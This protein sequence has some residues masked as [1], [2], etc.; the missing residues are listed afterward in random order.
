MNAS[1]SSFP[2][3]AASPRASSS[4]SGRAEPRVLPW[5]D[6]SF[7]GPSSARW[8]ARRS[9]V[10]LGIAVLLVAGAASLLLQPFGGQSAAVA[11]EASGPGPS[12]PIRILRDAQTLSLDVVYQHRLF[13][14]PE[15]P[16]QGPPADG[17][18][19]TGFLRFREAGKAWRAEQSV[20]ADRVKHFAWIDQSFDGAA[21]GSGEYRYHDRLRGNAAVLP[22]DAL[23]STLWSQQPLYWLASWA[24]SSSGSGGGDRL[25][26]SAFLA[27]SDEAISLADEGWSLVEVA[28]ADG[29]TLVEQLTV[30]S[31]GGGST[32]VLTAPKGEHDELLSIEEYAA[33]GTP[34][35]RVL[36][37][38]WKVPAWGPYSA[39]APR[40]LPH[41]VTVIGYDKLGM[42][43]YEAT[44]SI[45]ACA[46]DLP[47]SADDLTASLEGATTIV[48]E[49]PG[50]SPQ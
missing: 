43:L 7:G 31:G 36:F 2:R 47:M 42:S 1:P 12:S 15:T 40:T 16:W 30:P 25:T 29:V 9:G 23:A 46:V 20:D 11:N 3:S 34:I 32:C 44:L 27:L 33:D 39:L 13:A 17:T 50:G 14:E 38:G 18:P 22:S 45:V 4:S 48:D 19:T 41:A 49:T 21:E 6:E 24:A 8:Q 10:G 5:R 28:G 35:R 37:D 26:R